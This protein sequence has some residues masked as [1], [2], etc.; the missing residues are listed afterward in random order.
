M[1]QRP[2]L[3]HRLNPLHLYEPVEVIV[4]VKGE[5]DPRTGQYG[6]DTEEVLW[7]G[8][9]SIQPY[10]RASL[11]AVQEPVG[12]IALAVDAFKIYLPYEALTGRTRTYRIRSNGRYFEPKGKPQDPGGRHA[13]WIIIAAEVDR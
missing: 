8:F 9:G 11:T 4:R 7:H 1:M 10:I 12:G 5:Y 2:L 13:H 3:Q 6:D